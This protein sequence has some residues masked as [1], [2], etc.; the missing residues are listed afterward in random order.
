MGFFDDIGKSISDAGQNAVQKGKEMADVAKYNSLI[1]DEE[2]K[3]ANL[4]EQ[5]G[6][7]YVEL[8]GDSPEDS[9]KDYVDAIKLSAD[10]VQEYKDK[11][12]ELKGITKCASCGS[13]IPNGSLF[14][15]SCGAKVAEQ[16]AP[17]AADEIKCASCGA[18]IPAGSKF[19]VS[20]GKPVE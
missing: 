10:K 1:S 11:I 20:C 15:P 17:Q 4:Y 3:A 6:R 19:C 8:K 13:A 5:L 18:A 2:K 7:K 16:A 14:C 9:F 12:I